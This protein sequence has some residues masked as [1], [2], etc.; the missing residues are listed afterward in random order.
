MNKKENYSHSKIGTFYNCPRKFEFIYKKKY[1]RSSNVYSLKG[2]ILHAMIELY[3][4]GDDFNLP[5]EGEFTKLPKEEFDKFKE[6]FKTIKE[7]PLIKQLKQIYNKFEIVQMEK[8]LGNIFSEFA[9][10]GSADT[11]IKNKDKCIII[12]YKT[13]KVYEKWEQL[14]YYALMASYLYPDLTE[15]LLILSFTTFNEERKVK[16]IRED[17]N[18][19]EKEL[20]KKINEISST[21]IYYKN[22]S[23][24][25]DYCEYKKECMMKDQLDKVMTDVIEA[26]DMLPSSFK[27]PLVWDGYIDSNVTII[28]DHPTKIDIETKSILSEDSEEGLLLWNLMAEYELKR[29]KFLIINSY[30]YLN[31]NYEPLESKHSNIT[32]HQFDNILNITDSN[33]YIILG[34]ESFNK[35]TKLNGSFKHNTKIKWNNK[36]IYMFYHP[37]DIL[38]NIK[39]KLTYNLLGEIKEK[40]F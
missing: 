1:P 40:L 35:L 3:I 23:K 7:Q 21:E 37:Y 39:N 25:C 9:F 4:N 8:K 22:L 15:F 16:L 18:V 20:L 28:N 27:G 19:I 33:I 12:D 31:E 32:E 10:N 13:G 30:Y 29:H 38:N 26:R 17:L 5:Y 6:E 24:F 34:E 2:T 11:F 14:K 36:I